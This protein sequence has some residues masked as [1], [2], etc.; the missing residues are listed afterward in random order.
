[1]RA[2]PTPNIRTPLP[3]I[4]ALVTLAAVA[5]RLEPSRPSE[6]ISARHTNSAM[7][8]G[9]STTAQHLPSIPVSR[10]PSLYIVTSKPATHPYNLALVAGAAQHIGARVERSIRSLPPADAANRGPATAIL[11]SEIA[12]AR[13][14]VVVVCGEAA[15]RDVFLA[16]LAVRGVPTVFVGL[17]WPSRI[18]DLTLPGRQGMLATTPMGEVLTLLQNL[19]PTADA[20]IWIDA[21][22]PSALAR[23]EAAD[24]LAR[25]ER[26]RVN[27]VVATT[28]AAWR[29]AVQRAH[30]NA[31]F[32]LLD[33]PPPGVDARAAAPIRSV[34]SMHRKP[35]FAM[36]D[37]AA[38]FAA[39]HIAADPHALGAWGGQMASAIIDGIISGEGAIIPNRYWTVSVNPDLLNRMDGRL[40]AELTQ[41]QVDGP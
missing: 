9:P 24:E 1:M 35:S 13:P 20:A 14:D 15:Y 11:L 10:R 34:A 40:T 36:T 22:T 26:I 19:A 16:D 12:S 3:A 2:P 32:V 31:D 29:V 28:P 17:P 23:F 7:L 27:R 33:S 8:R 18:D 30:L 38:P 4:A 21:G 37:A 41:A 6:A 39:I 25:N 5:W